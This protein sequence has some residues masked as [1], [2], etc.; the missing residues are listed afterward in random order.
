MDDGGTLS[1]WERR[2]RLLGVSAPT[3][4][5]SRLNSAPLF[6]RFDQLRI[7]TMEKRFQFPFAHEGT[8][9]W[10]STVSVLELLWVVGVR[11]THHE[12]A[13]RAWQGSKRRSFLSHIITRLYS[14]RR[15]GLTTSVGKQCSVLTG[16]IPM[17]E[18]WPIGNFLIRYFPIRARKY[19]T[20]QWIYLGII[21]YF[22]LANGRG[23]SYYT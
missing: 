8:D 15:L 6:L 2:L 3:L 1:Y 23:P 22:F 13:W 10:R 12:A 16:S 7:E 19:S 4:H 20:S 17:Q 18:E 5:V 21:L 9:T 11:R 14:T